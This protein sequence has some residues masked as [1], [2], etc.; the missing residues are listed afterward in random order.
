MVHTACAEGLPFNCD[1]PLPACRV[2]ERPGWLLTRAGSY[3]G[4]D[5][6]ATEYGR[7]V[8]DTTVGCRS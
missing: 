6:Q 4:G 3:R 5:T 7:G 2:A 8:W 1:Q